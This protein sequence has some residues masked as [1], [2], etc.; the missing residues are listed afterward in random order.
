[1]YPQCDYLGAGKFICSRSGATTQVNVK[2]KIV[3]ATFYGTTVPLTH[4]PSFEIADGV[5]LVAPNALP[6]LWRTDATKP[7]NLV[8]LG[9]GKT[10]M[11][12]G[13]WLLGAGVAPQSIS[14]VMPRDSWLLNR[15]HTQPGSEFFHETFGGQVAQM[16]AL[17]TA[18]DL[19][20]LFRRL[21]ASGVM[22]RIDP[23]IEPSMYHCATMSQGEVDLLRKI[24]TVIRKG[25]VKSIDA[26]GMVLD[27]GRVAMDGPALYVDC[28]ATAIERRPPV[29][30]FRDNLIT[31]QMIRA[32]QPTFSAAMTAYLEAALEDEDQKN[33]F[34]GPVPL[35]EGLPEF[36][37]G[38]LMNMVNQFQW[39]RD[40]GIR[41]WMIDSRLDGF[42]AVIAAISKDDTEKQAVLK[43]FRGF[44][45]QA[46]ENINRLIAQQ[47]SG[48]ALN[49]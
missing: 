15:H 2:R 49:T 19:P 4:T 10:A 48:L 30:V 26:S 47:K 8:I 25:R 36:L 43:A 27:Q 32:C 29:P 38:M 1:Y 3:D 44:A 22:L 39:S 14:W 33:Q 9:A 46:P 18:T 21:E 16:E 11:D 45:R 34:S 35:P 12:V 42:S 6:G 24:K 37:T 20:D 17:A 7:E 13:V 28:T 40:P 5:E 23:E 41:Q 31:L